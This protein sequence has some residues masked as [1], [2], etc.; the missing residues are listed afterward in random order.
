MCEP[1]IC[2]PNVQ[3][4]VVMYMNSIISEND[5]GTSNTKFSIL[6]ELNIAYARILN[7]HDIQ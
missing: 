3:T 7:H 5:Y 2:A 6:L 4:T 1:I